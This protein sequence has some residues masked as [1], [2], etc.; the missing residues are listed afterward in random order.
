MRKERSTRRNKKEEGKT[1]ERIREGVANI[2][3]EKNSQMKIF[4]KILRR[5]FVCYFWF[6]GLANI[7]LGI[8][9]NLL[10]PNIE[11]HVPFG[12][13]RIGWSGVHDHTSSGKDKTLLGYGYNGAIGYIDKKWNLFRSWKGNNYK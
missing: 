12:F 1:R 13:F 3:Y 6:N 10:M 7:Q 2:Y 5:Q 8:H 11:I 9:L 4:P